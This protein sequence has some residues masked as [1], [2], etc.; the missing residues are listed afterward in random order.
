MTEQREKEKL[1]PQNTVDLQVM[2]TEPVLPSEY[3]SDRLRNKFRTFVHVRDKD[4][5]LVNDDEGNVKVAISRDF[6]SVMEI[7]TQD[8]RLGNLQNQELTFVRYNLDLCTDILTVLPEKFSKPALILLERSVAIIETSQSRKGFLRQL[9][10]TFFSNQKVATDE[11]KKRS[12]F[13]LGKKQ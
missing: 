12:F 3:I 5:K 6:W 9:F 2:T 13:G 4:G 11:P 7:F 8:W 10:N 1:R